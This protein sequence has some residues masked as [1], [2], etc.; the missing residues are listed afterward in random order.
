MRMNYADID[1]YPEP[2]MLS[3]EASKEVARRNQQQ[4]WDGVKLVTIS[5]ILYAL[6]FISLGIYDNL[7]H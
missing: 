1:P 3:D 7:V 2:S 4:I 6:F 5:L